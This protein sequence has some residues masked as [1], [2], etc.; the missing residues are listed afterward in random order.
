MTIIKAKRKF[1]IYL[2]LMIVVLG[3]GGAYAFNQWMP[4]QY[5]P[6]YPSIPLFFYIYGLIFIYLYGLFPDKWLAIQILGKGVKLIFGL[7]FVVAYAHFVRVH[8]K[9]FLLIFLCYYIIYL[10]FESAF[11]LKH[12]M[13]LKKEKKK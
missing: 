4:E 11:F 1:I 6:F 12:E 13:E 8:V 2:T 7:L 5:P 10:I 9:A 3:F